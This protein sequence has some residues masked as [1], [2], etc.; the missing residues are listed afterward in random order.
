MRDFLMTVASIL[1]ESVSD[2]Q[3]MRLCFDIFVGFVLFFVFHA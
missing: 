1:H 2:E 3:S